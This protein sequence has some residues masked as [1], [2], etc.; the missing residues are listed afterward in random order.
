MGT[1]IHLAAEIAVFDD[2]GRPAGWEY[3]PPPVTTCWSC[4]GTGR[5]GDK[6]CYW[7]CTPV[8]I[9][10]EP[11]TADYFEEINTRYVEPGKVREHWYHDRN[12]MVFAVLAD[13]RNGRGFAG[14]PTHRPITPISE[15]RGVPA[16]ATPE[17]LATLSNEHS[18]SWL[19]LSEVL[20]Y[21]WDQP[22][23]HHGVVSMTEFDEYL[24]TGA[25][26]SWCGDISGGAIRK[27]T[28][29]E[30]M[31]MVK[32]GNLDPDAYTS[33]SWGD[34]MAAQVEDFLT[35]MKVLAMTAGEVPVRLVF[36]FDS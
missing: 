13:V 28:M 31:A 27:V 6:D 29:D 32:A 9:D 1:D 33:I 19:M 34:S 17:S 14:V 20:A 21:D 7:C 12:Y 5:R 23:Q 22:I 26:S 10:G 8:W 2:D 24:R 3:L 18:A 11:G 16:D 4:E 15:P 36:D 25:P 30:A 35:T